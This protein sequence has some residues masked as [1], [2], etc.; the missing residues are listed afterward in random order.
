MR[1]FV[2]TSLFTLGQECRFL[3]Y[4]LGY[5][6]WIPWAKTLNCNRGAGQLRQGIQLH[7]LVKAGAGN[8]GQVVTKGFGAGQ[9]LVDGA[10]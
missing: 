5:L 1:Y 3:G 4:R 6:A 10:L 9:V 8:A 2:F 7:A